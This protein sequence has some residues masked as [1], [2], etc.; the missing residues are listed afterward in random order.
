M[1]PKGTNEL[2]GFDQG[3]KEQSEVMYLGGELAGSDVPMHLLTWSSRLQ[4]LSFEGTVKLGFMSCC[5]TP[6]GWIAPADQYN[7]EI[8]LSPAEESWLANWQELEAKV[9]ARFGRWTELLQV[10]SY[11]SQVLVINWLMTSM[12]WYRLVPLVPPPSFIA[13]IQR[14]LVHFFWDK[15]MHWVVAQV[16]TLPVEEG[17]PDHWNMGDSHRAYPLAGMVTIVRE[18]LYLQRPPLVFL[19]ALQPMLLIFGHPV[20]RGAD[21]TEDLLVGLLLGLAKLA[22]NRVM[23]CHGGD[24]SRQYCSIQV[25]LDK[26]INR[27]GK[28]GIRSFTPTNGNIFPMA[29]LSRPFNIFYLLQNSWAVVHLV[30]GEYSWEYIQ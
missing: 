8:C 26:Y 5:I 4:S 18:P 13:D 9:S 7:Q 11:R 28:E 21:K 23:S 6:C 29:I 25:V 30:Q 27:K 22:I 24:G 14:T 15:R 3:L 1:F 20:Q 19:V 2:Q 10:L 17:G 16:L 12:L